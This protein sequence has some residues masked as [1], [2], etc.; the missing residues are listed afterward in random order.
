MTDQ[1]DHPPVQSIADVAASALGHIPPDCRFGE[2]DAAAIHAHQEFLLGLEPHI[3][4][5]FYD[6]LYAYPPTAAVFVQGERPEREESLA[7]WWRKTVQGPLDDQYF[8]WMALVG[9]VH[10][11]RGV[12]NPAMLAMGDHIVERLA[13]VLDDLDAVVAAGIMPVEAERLLE[14]F[15]RLAMTIGAIITFGYTYGNEEAVG[16]ALYDIAGMP[17]R[18]VERLREQQIARAVARG[19]E[20]MHRGRSD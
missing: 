12:E 19:R 6:T 4:M 11:A 14:A 1:A 17:E 8:S 18:L 15:R 13:G 3:V 20:Q 7:Q 2:E 9:L 16:A 10:V 5:S